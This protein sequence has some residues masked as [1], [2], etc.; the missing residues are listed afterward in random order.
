MKKTIR[1]KLLEELDRIALGGVAY[2]GGAHGIM[3]VTQADARSL[4]EMI[5][6]D[7]ESAW[8]YRDLCK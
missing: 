5:R 7:A 2:E 8:M 4:A 3:H 6:Q 1:D